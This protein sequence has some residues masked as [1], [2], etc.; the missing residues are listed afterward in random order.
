MSLPKPKKENTE[1]LGPYS[2][3]YIEHVKDNINNVV[4][5]TNSNWRSY[6]EFF[7]I[8]RFILRSD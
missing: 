1:F 7:F 6:L 8:R 2:K 5:E 3:R 4:N